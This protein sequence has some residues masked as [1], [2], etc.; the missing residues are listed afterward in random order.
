ML[1]AM[2]MSQLLTFLLL[3]FIACGGEAEP[4]T[5]PT[6]EPLPPA[7]STV[8][9]PA[10][11]VTIK[12]LYVA[13]S[14]PSGTLV[15]TIA[16]DGTVSVAFDVLQNGRGPHVDATIKLAPNGT[17]AT[18]SAKGHHT[19]GTS[20]VETFARDGQRAR[21]KSNE[22]QGDRD[23]PSNAFFF[24]M[25]P[26]PDA[27]GMLARALLQAGGP[28]PLLPGGDVRLEKIGDATLAK[29]G[30]QRHV[31]GY[32]IFGLDLV[33]TYV[34]MND[35]GSWFG[36]VDALSSIVP[37]GWEG[38]VAPLVA[39]ENAADKRRDADTASRLGHRPPS[40]GLAFTHARVLDVVRAKWMDDQTVLVVGDR[41]LQLGASSSV[42][43][44]PGAEV[45][46]LAGKALLPGLW[47]MHVHFQAPAGELDIAS[48]VTTVRDV[49]NDPD[50]LDDFKKRLDEGAAVGP[51]LLRMG[52]VEGRG[53]KA[54][55]AKVT[56]ETPEEAK[57]A[58][59]FYA[60]RGYDGM[61]I[62]NSIKPEL[63]P[64]ITREAHARGM[65]VT[66]HVPVHVL[67]NEAVKAGYDGI[68]HIN[69]LFLNF[70]ATHDTDTRDTTR[71]TL[72]G[73]KAASLDLGS[74]PVKDL[75]ALLIEHH[76]VID[77]TLDAFEDL[78]VGKQ[79]QVIPGLETLAARLPVQVGRGFLLGGVPHEGKDELYAQ[80][81][82]KC[83]AMVKALAAAKVAVVVGTDE[84]LAG[85]MVHH[86]LALFVRAGIKPADA[87]RMATI[88]PARAMKKDKESGSIEKGK[89]A[90]LVVIDGDPLVRID[91]I[92][93]VVTTVKS[94]VV[95]A[96]APLYATLGV[97]PL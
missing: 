64:I 10:A 78:L 12:R 47:D 71:F 13:H 89:I 3:S 81:Y 7:T 42:K 11:A 74:K 39:I 38:S 9:A 68:E 90:D 75:F 54:A 8:P 82:D 67:A 50:K 36:N 4:P 14:R 2:R 37:E 26:I 21:W 86:E 84:D 31:V 73:D 40:A 70:F 30:E 80:S 52:L 65:Q 44:P 48:G 28:L 35:D 63:I 34:W 88:E 20:I 92:G 16:S 55:A 57:A 6:T 66:G 79:G 32:A 97:K 1:R 24:P 41:I 96:S 23:A 69:M 25:A 58:V 49:G 87:I 94:G 83:L 43:V 95:Y 5:V 29:G 15:S 76:T 62:Y 91:D 61:K 59:E 72:L 45:V 53:E 22:E 60:R 33:P 46:D 27:V 85:L 51:H 93:R 77:P 19:M 17:I 18:L 56:A